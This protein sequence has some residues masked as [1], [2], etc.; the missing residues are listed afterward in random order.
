MNN[1]LTLLATAAAVFGVVHQFEPFWRLLRD[2]WRGR[3]SQSMVGALVARLGILAAITL[4]AIYLAARLADA[5]FLTEAEVAPVLQP[6]SECESFRALAPSFPECGELAYEATNG[7]CDPGSQAWVFSTGD[8]PRDI[9]GYC[10]LLVL[11]A[12]NG[13]SAGAE[14]PARTSE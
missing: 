5:P 9:E 8:V 12:A 13:R 10:A 3:A 1:A 7:S 2:A 14:S 6:R 4:G 11:L